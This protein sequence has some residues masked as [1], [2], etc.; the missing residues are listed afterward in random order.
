VSRFSGVQK[1]QAYF[2]DAGITCPKCGGKVY[3][4]KTRKGRK[5]LGCENNNSDPMRFYDLG[6]AVKRNCPKCGSFLLKKYSGRKVQL[7]CSNENCDYVK[8]GKKKGR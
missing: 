8:R 3:I 4:K 5:Y 1:R 7:K 2:G 6:Y